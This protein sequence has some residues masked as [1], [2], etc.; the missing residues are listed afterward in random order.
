MPQAQIELENVNGIWTGSVEVGGIVSRRGYVRE[1]TLEAALDAVMVHYRG[2]IPNDPVEPPKVPLPPIIPVAP[3]PNMIV[4]REV[5][6]R[7][8]PPKSSYAG[9]VR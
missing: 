2:W 7:G 1:T 4:S 6:R 9:G 3:P 5:R 8:R